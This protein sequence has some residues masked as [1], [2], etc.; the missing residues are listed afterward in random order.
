MG[1][2]LRI[3]IGEDYTFSVDPSEYTRKTGKSIS[4]IARMVVLTYGH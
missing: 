4:E 1:Y 3:I 2:E